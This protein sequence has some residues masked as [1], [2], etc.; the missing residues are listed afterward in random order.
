VRKSILFVDDEPLVLQGLRRMLHDLRKDWDMHFAE[1]GEQALALMSRTT[2]DVV[3]SDMR[4]PGMNGAQLLNHVMVRFPKTVRIILSGHADKDLILKCVG[5]T[6]QYLS[7]PC[8]PQA[9]RATVARATLLESSLENEQLRRLVGRM[10]RLPSIPALYVRIVDRLQSSDVALDEI[11][12]IVARDPGMTAKLLKLVNSAFFGLRREISSPTEAV[13]YLGLDTVKSLV[14]SIDAFSQFESASLS[15]VPIDRFWGHS[16]N[17]ATAARQIA[18]LEDAGQKVAEESFA[19]GLLHD[20]GKL[21][22]AF[23][24]PERYGLSIKQAMETKQSLSAI[25]QEQL[26][27]DH[28]AVGGYLLGLWGLPVPVVEAIALHHRPASVPSGPFSP[29][30]AVHVADALTN[31]THPADGLAGVAD[32]D[33]TCL[34]EAGVQPRLDLWR[35]EVSGQPLAAA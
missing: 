3:V 10:D 7:K 27:A 16:L 11:G 22:L 14:L 2:V 33:E 31:S 18:I 6:H 1:N 9:L 35:R 8:E 30:L 26:G 4:M 17:V 13:V 15:G 12:E 23:N 19:A 5:S 32:P 29:L 20:T 28:A 21:I 25:E 24:F 34:A